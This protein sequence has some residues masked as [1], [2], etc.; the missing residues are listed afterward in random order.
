[1]GEISGFF[2]GPVHPL[3]ARKDFDIIL[4]LAIQKNGHLASDLGPRGHM[5]QH[6]PGIC[7]KPACMFTWDIRKHGSTI[8]PFFCVLKIFHGCS[9][10]GVLIPH[11]RDPLF[12][13]AFGRISNHP[14]F[15]SMVR[16]SLRAPKVCYIYEYQNL[17]ISG[18]TGFIRHLFVLFFF[19]FFGGLLYITSYSCLTKSFH[20]FSLSMVTY[21]NY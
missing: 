6:S 2:W 12:F 10:D 18:L 14:N 16:R 7:A 17:A 13:L 5:F 11:S 3:Q 15:G 4:V 1:M 20:H 19:G 8:F 9:P 21:R